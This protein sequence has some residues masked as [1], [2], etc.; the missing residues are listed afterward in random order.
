M[1]FFKDYW[2]LGKRLANYDPQAKASPP[3]VFINKVLLEQGHTHSFT[4]CFW[5]LLYYNSCNK[6]SMSH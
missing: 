2:A 5:L 3:F 1:T 6:D 4:Y